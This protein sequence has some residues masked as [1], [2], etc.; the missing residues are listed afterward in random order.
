MPTVRNPL[1]TDRSG[2]PPTYECAVVCPAASGRQK[3]GSCAAAPLTCAIARK[4]PD[5]GGCRMGQT[6]FSLM[7]PGTR[8]KPH[9]GPTNTRVRLH[10][11]LVV[12]GG[13]HIKQSRR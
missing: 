11:G 3:T 1:L 2:P 4:F 8:V 12:P 5:A 6:K 10:L 7:N 9:A 13:A